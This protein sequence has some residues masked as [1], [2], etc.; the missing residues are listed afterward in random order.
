MKLRTAAFAAFVLAITP[1]AMLHVDRFTD[2]LKNEG[3]LA[4]QYPRVVRSGAIISHAASDMKGVA[5]LGKVWARFMSIRFNPN[6]GSC[7]DLKTAARFTGDVEGLAKE[8]K[9]CLTRLQ[10]L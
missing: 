2:V 7:I 4:N 1:A 6:L 3:E 10:V 5:D 8:A 9:P